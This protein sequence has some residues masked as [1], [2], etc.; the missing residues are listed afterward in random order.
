MFKQK[1]KFSDAG[2]KATRTRG[3]EEEYGVT[4]LFMGT[5]STA[6]RGREMIY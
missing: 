6:P 2:G 4:V 3:R 1:L 5:S